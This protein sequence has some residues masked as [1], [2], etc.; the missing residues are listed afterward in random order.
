MSYFL[1]E[2]FHVEGAG[3]PQY[4]SITIYLLSEESE[5]A[6]VLLMSQERMKIKKLLA[7]SLR[8]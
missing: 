7:Q 4:G 8:D 2:S 1:I 6:V 5:Y 3:R